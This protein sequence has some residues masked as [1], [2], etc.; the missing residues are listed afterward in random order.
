M[1]DS[2]KVL[3]TLE[4]QDNASDK[5]QSV[6]DKLQQLSSAGGSGGG[7]GFFNNMSA[8]IDRTLDGMERGLRGFTEFTNRWTSATAGIDRAIT[9]VL[10][11]AGEAVYDFTSEAI[12]NYMEFSKQHAMTMGVMANNAA[13]KNNPD[14]QVFFNDSEQ[15]KNQAMN[16]GMFG[17]TGQGSLSTVTEVSDLQT[18]L[19]KAGLDPSYLLS[20]SVTSD[21]LKFAQANQLKTS[22]AVDFAVALGNQFNVPKEDW[23]SMLD[24]VSH[25][26]DLST[27]DVS[28]IVNSMKYAG[29]ITS[30]LGRDLEETLGLIAVQGNFGLKGSQSGSSI[31]ALMT[32][33]LT[34]D[35]TV[36]TNAQ[37]EVAPPKALEAFYEFEKKVKPDGNLLPMTEVQDTLEETMSTLNDEEQA[38]FAKKLFGLYQMKGAYALINGDMTLDE[39]IEEI[40]NQSDG[41]NDNKLTQLLNSSWGKYTSLENMWDAVQTDFGERLSP[42][43]N[44]ILDELFNF[45]SNNGNYD[46][47]FDN[48]RDGLQKASDKI[49][50]RYGQALGD[51]VNNIGSVAIDLTEIGATIGPE[52]AKGLATVVGG[53][54]AKDADG[55]TPGLFD[56][57]T[58]LFGAPF[59]DDWDGMIQNMRDAADGLPDDLKE[60]ANNVITAA[61]AFAKL[62]VID[63][64]VGMLG[65]LG[66]ALLGVVIIAQ[67][68]KGLIDFFGKFRGG[69][70]TPGGG[71]GGSTIPSM[72]VTTE[73]MYVNAGTVI[74]NGGPGGTPG[75]G[76]MPMPVPMNGGMPGTGT[77]GG[78]PLQEDDENEE[79]NTESHPNV[80]PLPVPW[81]EPNEEPGEQPAADYE[82]GTNVIPFPSFRPQEEREAAITPNTSP[83]WSFYNDFQQRRLENS[84]LFPSWSDMLNNATQHATDT[85]T[86]PV[87]QPT[88]VP[89]RNEEKSESPLPQPSGETEDAHRW[90]AMTPA[91]QQAAI[92]RGEYSKY[93]N[94]EQMLQGLAVEG[95]VAL[96]FLAPLL[97]EAGAAAIPWLAGAGAG[98]A[99]FFGNAVPVGAEGLDEGYTKSVDLGEQGKYVAQYD[100]EGNLISLKVDTSE[101][102]AAKQKLTE[103]STSDVSVSVNADGNIDILSEAGEKTAELDGKAASMSLNADGNIDIFDEAGNKIAEVD[104]KTG[105]VTITA[106][107]DATDKANSARDAINGIP[108]SKNTTLNATDGITG[109]ASGAKSSIWQIPGSKFT[110]LN[111]TDGTSSKAN[112]ARNSVNGVPGSKHTAL[113]A[114]DG[115]SAPSNNARNAVNRVPASKHTSLTASDGVSG[116]AATVKSVLASIPRS[117]TVAINAVASGIS[118][119]ANTVK[120]WFGKETGESNASENQPVIINDQDIADPTEIVEHNGTK[121]WFTMPDGSPV[122]NLPLKLRAGDKVYTASQSREQ[123]KKMGVKHYEDGT[124][125]NVDDGIIDMSGYVPDMRN[126]VMSTYN[127]NLSMSNRPIS[128]GISNIPA[129]NVEAPNVMVSVN[130]DKD[131]NITKEVSI[132]DPSQTDRLNKWYSRQSARYGSSTK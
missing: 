125:N 114:S 90:M 1:A 66:N 129:V 69:G 3:F 56:I 123:L 41:T 40:R 11:N 2:E 6:I 38:W 87:A 121:Y 32:R 19:L 107:D 21:V 67:G 80:I 92:D 33:L 118:S 119:A 113:T 109:K 104:G 79:I 101:V 105:E 122:R 102:D 44:A 76:G 18:Q 4:A 10:R 36:I 95:L 82:P 14:P 75:T 131:G 77:G 25:A 70:T 26:A 117:I 88:P 52:F 132:L 37:K 63:N 20:T 98:A 130:V 27:I 78:T 84:A 58:R 43:T 48:L 71:G 62:Y 23:G 49:A 85:S 108:S 8:S 61:D 35:T 83:E 46:I 17:P 54:F 55:N 51:A 60:L 15:L 5:I 42:F 110:V 96:P 120:G 28:H 115:T 74:I 7:G 34:G 81:H 91:E 22:D 13:Y 9:N 16:L 112:T 53:I 39:V 124:G 86:Q 59:G 94:G 45:L 50:E 12:N 127:N 73:V 99:T 116:V 24:K 29:G 57:I 100:A 128:S 111:A 30:G 103:L 68:M 64:V 97:A 65:D 72:N 89:T 31:Q 126:V 47:N 106:T 93:S